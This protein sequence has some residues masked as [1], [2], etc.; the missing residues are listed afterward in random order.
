MSLVARFVRESYRSGQP[1]QNLSGVGNLRINGLKLGT[2]EHVECQ[3]G[4]LF[5]VPQSIADASA[6]CAATSNG[7]D[8]AMPEPRR[9]APALARTGCGC[10]VRMTLAGTALATFIGAFSQ[11]I[12]EDLIPKG[13]DPEWRCS[14]PR[15]KLNGVK[16]P[17]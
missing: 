5:C 9:L 11:A 2:G 14:S 1:L 4:F 13:N 10:L 6:N 17:L 3:F 12:V 16:P 8:D 7:C 15:P